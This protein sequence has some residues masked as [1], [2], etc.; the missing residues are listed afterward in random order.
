[1]EA[2]YVFHGAFSGSTN[3]I[4]PDVD[5]AMFALL[6]DILIKAFNR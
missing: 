1:L 3:K 5:E 2:A 6:L 4:D